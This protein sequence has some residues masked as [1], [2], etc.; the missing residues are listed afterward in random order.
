MRRV[1]L[2]LLDIQTSTSHSLPRTKLP[3]TPNPPVCFFPRAQAIE[4]IFKILR[5]LLFPPQI[6]PC[7][8]HPKSQPWE[9]RH[10]CINTD[11]ISRRGFIQHRVDGT[12]AGCA[13]AAVRC[14]G[15]QGEEPRLPGHRGKVVKESYPEAFFAGG[16]IPLCL[17]F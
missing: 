4:H 9:K 14:G 15:C 10:H 6:P 13:W 2:F 1:P 7:P 16:P 8:S 3:P 5:L 11:T 12:A 17:D